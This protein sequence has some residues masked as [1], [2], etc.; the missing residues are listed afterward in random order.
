MNRLLGGTDDAADHAAEHDAVERCDGPPV[1]VPGQSAR[2]ERGAL[3]DPIRDMS[4]AAS[5]SGLS[6][7]RAPRARVVR[8]V[9]T[10]VRGAATVGAVEQRVTRLRGGM[11]RP[12]IEGTGGYV[13]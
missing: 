8:Q 11:R 5:I 3:A 9:A 13:L 10:A 12:A 7:P 1:D 2:R 6:V 4:V